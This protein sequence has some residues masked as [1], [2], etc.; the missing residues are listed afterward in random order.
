MR[1]IKDLPNLT[2]EQ[3]LKWADKH[4]KRTGEWPRQKSGEV[5]TGTPG[6]TWLGI[7]HSLRRGSRGLPGGSSLAKLLD[8]K[9]KKKT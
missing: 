5:T 9:R 6:E 1:N 7:D 4:K 3:I 8:E 2:I